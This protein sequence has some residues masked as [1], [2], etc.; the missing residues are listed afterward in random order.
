MVAGKPVTL[1]GTASADTY[2][3]GE[4]VRV[5]FQYPGAKVQAR[6]ANGESIAI[7]DKLVSNGNGE[8]KEMTADSSATIAEEVLIAIAEEACDMSDSS[9]ADP[10]GLCKVRIV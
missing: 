8:L 4:V 10:D 2:S 7:G 5:H 9:A 6:I 1:D 3:D